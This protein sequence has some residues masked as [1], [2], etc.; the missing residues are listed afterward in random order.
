MAKPTNQRKEHV[1]LNLLHEHALGAHAVEHLQQ[2]GTQQ[3]LGCN[4]G[5]TAFDVGF[6]HVRKQIV[7]GH[8]GLVD[9]LAYGTQR[10]S[11]WDEII[12]PFHQKQALGKGVSAAHVC[13]IFV[14][15]ELS[16]EQ[17]NWRFQC[18]SISAAC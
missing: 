14:M 12:E 6:I 16:T 11:R 9:H 3:L 8:Q 10:V 18:V 2:H 5:T 7:H 17:L 15:P 13:L 1:V 4:A